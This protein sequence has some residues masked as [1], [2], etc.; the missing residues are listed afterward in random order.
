VFVYYTHYTYIYICIYIYVLCIYVERERERE[1]ERRPVRSANSA[2]RVCSSAY[3]YI[4]Y[5][6]LLYIG[7]QSDLPTAHYVCVAAHTTI[8]LASSYYSISSVL[9][10]LGSNPPIS[11]ASSGYCASSVLILL[12]I[13]RPHTT[14]SQKNQKST[15]T[16]RCRLAPIEKLR[17]SR[18]QRPALRHRNLRHRLR[19]LLHGLLRLSLRN[20]LRNKKV[21]K[22][23]GGGDSAKTSLSVL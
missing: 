8:Y 14:R 3:Y 5:Y 9:I 2:L 20:L 15:G 10:L 1:R 7:D 21:R 17:L 23:E 11:P 19:Y 16:W 22:G 4:Y 12:H 6:I 18:L 13:W